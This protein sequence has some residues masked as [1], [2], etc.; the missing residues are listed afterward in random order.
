MAEPSEV[1]VNDALKRRL[2]DID[3][4][5]FAVDV[6]ALAAAFMFWRITSAPTELRDDADG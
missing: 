4:A 2:G 6:E 5:E 3:P 1:S